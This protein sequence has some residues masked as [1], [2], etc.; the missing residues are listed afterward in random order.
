M[1][2]PEWLPGHNIVLVILASR[3]T[4]RQDQR[5]NVHKMSKRFR[6]LSWKETL[7]SLPIHVSSAFSHRFAS[8]QVFMGQNYLH[9]YKLISN[10]DEGSGSCT[11][12]NNEWLDNIHSKSSCLTFIIYIWRHDI[13]SQINWY[14]IE[15]WLILGL[16]PA[17][18]RRRYKV[19]PPLIGW[20]QIS[21]ES[22]S[23]FMSA[24]WIKEDV[25]LYG[26]CLILPHQIQCDS[27]CW[28][29]QLLYLGIWK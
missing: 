19:T 21:P 9:L 14:F 26:D 20:A 28:F 23:C 7:L 2:W 4:R 6:L 16:H 11:S 25:V 5:L 29:C 17:N 27:Y 24:V 15:S 10:Q 22:A 1:V 12:G 18:E 8:I 13:D 3:L